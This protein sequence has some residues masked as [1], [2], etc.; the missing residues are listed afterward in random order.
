MVDRRPGLYVHIPFC[1]AVCPYCDF[2][3]VRSQHPGR[4]GFVEHLVREI[5]LVGQARSQTSNGEVSEDH[6]GFA[7]FGAAGLS[8]STIYFGGGTPSALTGTE[9]HQMRRALE[10]ELPI[11]T[12]ARWSI[13]A[14]PEDIDD[15]VLNTWGSLGFDYL[16]L[17]VQSFSD[18]ALQF[19]GRRHTADQARIACERALESSFTTVSVDLMMGFECLPQAAWEP[20][21]E[22]AI[23]LGPQ[24]LSCYELTVHDGTAFRRLQ[25]AGELNLFDE[26]ERAAQYRKTVAA[27]ENSGYRQY[28]V[29]NF[30]KSEVDRSPHNQKYWQSAPYLG[31]GPSAHSFDGRRRWWNKRALKGWSSALKVG[32]SPVAE[33]EELSVEQQRME[34]LLTRIR[35]TKGLVLSEYQELFG[36]RLEEVHNKPV[37]DLVERGLLQHDIDALRPSVD[38]LL[39]ADSIVMQLS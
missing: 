24:H 38:G 12:D 10:R 15:A 23:T 25:Q 30:A 3:V 2:A 27:L 21:L 34:W 33:V 35:T 32:Q 5:E 20:V 7:V 36:H 1:S 22:T 13:E 6:P 26:E 18:S 37:T 9:L 8:F 11:S 17:G 14:N 28:E 39:L 19:L 16:S 29:S 31:L 4:K